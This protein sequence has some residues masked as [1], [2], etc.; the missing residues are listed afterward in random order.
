MM[1]YFDDILGQSQEILLG[2]PM[3]M[4]DRGSANILCDM[5]Q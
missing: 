3:M 4:W 2:R 1:T 5:Q